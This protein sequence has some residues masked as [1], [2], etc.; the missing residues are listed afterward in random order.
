MWMHDLGTTAIREPTL[1]RDIAAVTALYNISN[2]RA[3]DLLAVAEL[4]G[5]VFSP[6]HPVSLRDGGNNADEVA[7]AVAPLATKYAAAPQRIALAW[8]LHLSSAMLP[9]QAR[10]ASFTYETTLPPPV[11]V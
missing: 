1:D 6:W 8:L 3:P 9:I 5:A 11:L 2:R 7:V 10:Q 4:A